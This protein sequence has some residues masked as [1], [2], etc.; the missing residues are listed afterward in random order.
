MPRWMLTSCASCRESFIRTLRQIQL[1]LG[2]DLGRIARRDR[3]RGL[4]RPEADGGGVLVEMAVFGGRDRHV[5]VSERPW[6]GISKDV[7]L[8]GD[9]CSNDSCLFSLRSF[10]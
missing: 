9:S 2:G 8:I 7:R 1:L 4:M 5:L 3:G 6:S 10:I